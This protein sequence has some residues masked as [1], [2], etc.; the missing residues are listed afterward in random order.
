MEVG[1]VPD[2]KTTISKEETSA[3]GVVNSNVIKI[4]MVSQCICYSQMV[5]R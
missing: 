4:M 1:S 3:L 5:K 2:V